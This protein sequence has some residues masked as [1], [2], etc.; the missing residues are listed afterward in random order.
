MRFSV[1]SSTHPLM[2]AARRLE[3][4]DE[5]HR[6]QRRPKAAFGG[7]EVRRF[8]R[9]RLF[10]EQ[11]IRQAKLDGPIRIGE[12]ADERTDAC[13][14]LLRRALRCSAFFICSAV[15]PLPRPGHRERR[16]DASQATGPCA[17]SVRAHPLVQ[18]EAE[19]VAWSFAK[20]SIASAETA[21]ARASREEPNQ[22]LPELAAMGMGLALAG[23]ENLCVGLRMGARGGLGARG[24]RRIVGMCKKA[25]PSWR[26]TESAENPESRRVARMVR[27]PGSSFR[28]VVMSRSTT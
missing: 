5:V 4:V 3:P 20:R 11:T 14:H 26:D 21:G 8:E 2:C 17:L 27:S 12:R 13:H 22:L 28:K 25:K 23:G 16:G 19:G 7:V 10:A 9:V 1:C 6:L 15:S 18:V 24:S